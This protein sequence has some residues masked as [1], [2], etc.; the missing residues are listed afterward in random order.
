[1]SVILGAGRLQFAVPP[2]APHPEV[3]SGNG[4]EYAHEDEYPADP[5]DQPFTHGRDEYQT[6]NGYDAA[7]ADSDAR[8]GAAHAPP[9]HSE[10]HQC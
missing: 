8:P 9:A 3:D 5:F 10:P 6:E 2:W 1:M 4:D 7:A